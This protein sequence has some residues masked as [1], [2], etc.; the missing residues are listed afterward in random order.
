MGKLRSS[1]GGEIVDLVSCFDD[2]TCST[3]AAA[4][5]DGVVVLERV[6]THGTSGQ[7]RSSARARM[8]LTQQTL[9]ALKL[10]RV[11]VPHGAK[12]PQMMEAVQKHLARLLGPSGKLKARE[13]L[14]ADFGEPLTTGELP[15]LTEVAR[16][17]VREEVQ[18]EVRAQLGGAREKARLQPATDPSDPDNI[19]TQILPL[20]SAKDASPPQD[21]SAKPAG[22]GGDPQFEPPKTDATSKHGKSR[23]K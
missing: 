22:A 20:S 7:G 19:P 10:P 14:D 13:V 11:R 15:A 23:G 6:F 2:A 17:F 9:E 1:L 8:H 4:W 12:E 3:I 5:P 18:A 21:V 16:A